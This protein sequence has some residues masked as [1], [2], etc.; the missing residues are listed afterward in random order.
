VSRNTKLPSLSSHAC[1]QYQDPRDTLTTPTAM[2]PDGPRDP[3]AGPDSGPETPFP[4]RLDGKVIKG[5]GRGSK[6]VCVDFCSCHAR[7]FPPSPSSLRRRVCNRASKHIVSLATLRSSSHLGA[8]AGR[9]PEC[10]HIHTH[11]CMQPPVKPSHAIPCYAMPAP[12]AGSS[13]AHSCRPFACACAYERSITS[14]YT[15]R[16]ERG[17][18]C[19][20]PAMRNPAPRLWY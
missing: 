11:A 10:L 18:C 4:L 14:T 3:T 8:G 2:R 19:P 13:L 5:F 16:R 20:R 1:I 17:P 12:G 15:W 6:E 7:L 9:E